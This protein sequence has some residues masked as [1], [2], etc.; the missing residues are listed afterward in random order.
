MEIIGPTG[1]RG[2]RGRWMMMPDREDRRAAQTRRAVQ[3]RRRK[4]LMFLV[5]AAPLTLLLAG[6]LGGGLWLVNIVADL[7]LGLFLI[8]LR[9]AKHRRDEQF[10][11]VRPLARRGPPLTHDQRQP[12]RAGGRR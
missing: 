10:A 8:S 5:A 6:W 2:L 3:E 12:L 1:T 7:S 4:A 9:E 11:K